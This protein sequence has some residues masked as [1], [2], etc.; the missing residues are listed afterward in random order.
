ME[1]RLNQIDLR[2]TKTFRIGRTRLDGNVDLYNLLNAST[3]LAHVD[4][5][6]PRFM[7]PTQILGARIVDFGIQLNF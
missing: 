2:L 7:V 3:V 5:I 6:G 4:A 1:D